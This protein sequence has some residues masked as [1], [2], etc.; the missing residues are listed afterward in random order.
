MVVDEKYPI[1]PE[2]IDAARHPFDAFGDYNVE[3]AAMSVIRLAQK[4]GCWD[5]FTGKEVALHPSFLTL[6]LE[7]KLL[8]KNMGTYRATHDLVAGVFLH[9]PVPYIGFRE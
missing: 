5:E 1:R 6:L 7:R 3:L 2:M 9:N 4:K 8:T